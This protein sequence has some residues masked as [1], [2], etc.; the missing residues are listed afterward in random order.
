VDN[1]LTVIAFGRI[2]SSFDGPSIFKE[3]DTSPDR[4]T[5]DATKIKLPRIDEL[6]KK[7]VFPRGDAAMEPADEPTVIGVII[8]VI[9]MFTL[10]AAESA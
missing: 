10:G 1:M 5:L 6:V 4:V 2:Y 7:Y 3:R 8:G 9:V